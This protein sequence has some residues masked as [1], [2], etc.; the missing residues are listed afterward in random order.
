MDRDPRLRRRRGLSPIPEGRGDLEE[1]AG[2]Q[3][4]PILAAVP[5]VTGPLVFLHGVLSPGTGIV[6]RTA[7]TLGKMSNQRTSHLIRTTSPAHSKHRHAIRSGQRPFVTCPRD[8]E[9]D[10]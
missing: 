4:M 7:T 8:N 10:K 3:V 2:R 1:V 5:G 9:I 6:T